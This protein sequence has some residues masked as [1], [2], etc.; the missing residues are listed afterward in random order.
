[1]IMGEK[2]TK[3]FAFIFS[4]HLRGVTWTPGWLPPKGEILPFS[5]WIHALDDFKLQELAKAGGPWEVGDPR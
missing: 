3:I 1:M 5:E 2:G 4:Q